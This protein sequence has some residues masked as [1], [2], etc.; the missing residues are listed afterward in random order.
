M[1]LWLIM[2]L[3]PSLRLS[4]PGLTMHSSF[5]SRTRKTRKIVIELGYVLRHVLGYPIVSRRVFIFYEYLAR[6]PTKTPIW[7]TVPDMNL[8]AIGQS[9]LSYTLC[10]CSSSTSLAITLLRGPSYYVFHTPCSPWHSGK[11]ISIKVPRNVRHY[12]RR[13]IRGPRARSLRFFPVLFLR[14]RVVLAPLLPSHELS[15]D[16]A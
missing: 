1:G 6:T 15:H 2:R 12:R 5:P 7:N 14:S 11:F 16:R 8:R 13:K 10:I 3:F 9:H 4:G